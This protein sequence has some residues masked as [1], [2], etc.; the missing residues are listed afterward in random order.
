MVHSHVSHKHVLVGNTRVPYETKTNSKNPLATQ[1]K[2][3]FYQQREL[4]LIQLLFHITFQSQYVLEESQLSRVTKNGHG[5]RSFILEVQD[6]HFITPL[7]GIR[8]FI[9][10]MYDFIFSG[11]RLKSRHL[12]CVL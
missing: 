11:F 9:I 7:Y 4:Y 3:G 5:S 1:D 6:F 8:V 12:N 2:D 10:Y